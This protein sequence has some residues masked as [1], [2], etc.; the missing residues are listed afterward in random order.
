MQPETPQEQK[1]AEAAPTV[2]AE[3]EPQPKSSQDWQRFKEA[4]AQERKRAEELAVLAQKKAQE[5]EALKAALEAA[6]NKQQPMQE[7]QDP[8]DDDRIAKRVEELLTKK[9]QERER[10]R[11]EREKQELPK[12]LQQEHRDFEQ[13]CTTENLDYLEYHHP[14]IAAGY[15]YM[16]EG[17]EKWSNIYKAIKKYVPNTNYQPDLKRAEKNLAKPQS[18]SSPAVAQPQQSIAV[19]LDDARKAANWE[20]MQRAMKGLD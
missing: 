7:Y 17:F 3:P 2:Q 15:R 19:V 13:I 6:L 14:E 20:R 9:E 16:P 18:V 1:V 4:R 8:S 12:R 10:Q 11:L 5:A